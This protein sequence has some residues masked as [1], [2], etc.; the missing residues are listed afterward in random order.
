[1][2]QRSFLAV[3]VLLGDSI[4]DAI[5]ALPDGVGPAARASGQRPDLD[6]LATN[7]RDPRRAV[8]AK[9][10]ALVAQEVAVAIGEVTWR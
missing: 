1:V 3:S 7:L 6:E 4:D 2:W 9:S 8:R 5:A 10:L